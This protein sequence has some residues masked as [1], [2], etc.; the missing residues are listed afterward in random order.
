VV[1]RGGR[2]DRLMRLREARRTSFKLQDVKE[3]VHQVLNIV[4]VVTRH[5]LPSAH[6][7]INLDASYWLASVPGSQH[8]KAR[9]I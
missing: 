7:E 9:C 2:D 1:A 8:T 4:F 3:Q 5:T 6:S